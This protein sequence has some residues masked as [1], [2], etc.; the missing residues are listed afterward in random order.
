MNDKYSMS[1]E[2]NIFLARKKWDE[3]IYSG[4]R[5]ENRN[6]TFPQTQT[7]LGGINVGSVALGDV[8]AILNMRDAWRELLDTIDEPLTLEHIC[9]LNGLVSRNESLKWGVL[10]TGMVGIS[11]TGYMPAIPDEQNIVNELQTILSGDMTNTEKALE[12]F[13]WGVHSQLFWDG[14]KR[15][16]LLVANKLLITGGNGLLTVKEGNMLEFST[17]LTDYYNSHDGKP[18]K[19]FLYEHAIDGIG[20]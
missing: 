14:N 18:L 11:G 1:R 20:H 15:T 10:R 5:M 17:L 3:N 13:L 9:R 2:E 7:I 8:Q 4:M 6:V 19:A 16:S 12:L